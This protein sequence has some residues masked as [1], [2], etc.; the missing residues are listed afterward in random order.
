MYTRTLCYRLR[1]T[2]AYVNEYRL[3]YTI[4]DVV[5]HDIVSTCTVRKMREIAR[6]NNGR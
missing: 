1:F 6:Q 4:E 3:L 2:S 5:L